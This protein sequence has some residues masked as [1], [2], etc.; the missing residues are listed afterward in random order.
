MHE[1]VTEELLRGQGVHLGMTSHEK[2]GRRHGR[3]DGRWR[4][5]ATCWVC[6]RLVRTP[7]LLAEEG[8]QAATTDGVEA[9]QELWRLLHAL[10][11][12]AAQRV[13]CRHDDA[14]RGGLEFRIDRSRC[15][16]Q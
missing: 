8:G 7:R 16:L 4:G 15:L 11:D 2:V 6:A 3:D 12:A 14:S 13:K 9:G 1:R 10:T 5:Q